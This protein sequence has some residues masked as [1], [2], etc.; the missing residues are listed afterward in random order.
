LTEIN[1]YTELA[2]KLGAPI[3]RRFLALLE[4][5]MNSDEARLC[6]ELFTPATAQE[7]ADRLSIAKNNVSKILQS[8]VDRGI[9]TKGKTQYG[10]HTTLL[11]FHHDMSDAGV[12][13]GPHAISQKEKDKWQDFFV[14]EWA[15]IFLKS[16]ETN[17]AAFR[18]RT[19][20]PAIGAIEM[21]PNISPDQIL[22]EEN[23]KLIIEKAE[24]KILAPCGCRVLWGTP[25]GNCKDQHP[26]MRCFACFDNAR[27]RYYIDKPGRLL[28]EYSL[29]ETLDLVYEA[30]KSGL[31]HWGVCYCCNHTCEKLFPLTRA[32]KLNLAAPNRFQ[33]FVNEDLC[34]GCQDCVE[35][36]QF[37]AIEMRKGSG[38]KRLKSHIIAENCKGCGVCIVGCRQKALRYEIVRPPEYLKSLHQAG[39]AVRPSARTGGGGWGF[40]NLQ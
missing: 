6:I 26:L 32:N 19:I 29:K 22:P 9:L 23:W 4:A 27:G 34:I 16:Y 15:D 25:G 28:K 33:A 10:F 14:N 18:A 37:N 21:S 13:T 1:T 8:L 38:P 35:R 2:T 17:Q 36:C 12:L 3:S 31:V 39:A 20:W 30:E 7:L 11:G 5:T 24:R 40:Y